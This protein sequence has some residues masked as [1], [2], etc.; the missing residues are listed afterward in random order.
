MSIVATGLVLCAIAL[1][2]IP[3][4]AEEEA[5][6]GIGGRLELLVDNHL[7]AAMD[8]TS[9]VLHRPVPR[10]KVLVFDKP[11]EGR[12]CGYV[13]VIED[14]GTYRLY[15][16]GLPES[17]A[18]GSN[19]ET[20]C[21]AESADG[22]TWTK[23]DLGIFEVD[24][25]RANNVILS[26]MAPLSHNFS[27]LLDTRPGV[28]PAQRFKALGGT[29]AS[30]LAAFVSADGIHWTKLREEAVI[31]E[32]ALDS[33][34]VAFW[35]EPE[36]CYVCYLRTWSKGEFAGIRTISRT[37]SPDFLTW[38]PLVPMT[39]GD[40]PLEHLYTNQTRPYF[41]APHIYIA[42]AARFMPGRRVV[43]AA[44]FEKLGGETT[45]S[46]DCSDTVLMTS[47]GGQVYDRTFM[48]SFVRPGIGLMNWSSR[49]NY[50]A[51]GVVPT[52]DAEMSM[53]IQRAYGQ[54]GHCLQRL[55][56]R[57][58]GFASIN[59]PYAGGEFATKPF[60]FA[61]GRLVINYSTSAAGSVWVEIQGASGAP[62]PSFAHQDADEII[63][64]EIARA[65]SW[66]G[67]TDVGALAGNPVRL[68]F[69]MK[70]ADLYS[71]HFE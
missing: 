21:Y 69:M 49:T 59:A 71:F 44:Q 39:F 62:V 68:R 67:N 18:D 30:G 27:P 66:K 33:Q 60:T 51:Y 31:T 42:I 38:S 54:T 1:T 57:T 19:S 25:T 5:V 37:T 29:A 24:G 50:P 47:R 2:A 48:E 40:T 64:D 13:T 36:Q 53:Y 56:M 65:V 41:R 32:G 20:T 10:E 11:W 46:A 8:G 63:G 58:D 22:V 6:T 14:G 43:T 12:Y 28:D 26:G 52:G 55:T 23:P 16:R 4:S 35:S 9:L 15:Y 45:Y 70:D 17:K 3:A 34:N 7:I 61:G